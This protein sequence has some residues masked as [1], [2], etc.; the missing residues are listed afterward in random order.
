MCMKSGFKCVLFGPK[1]AHNLEV[2]WHCGTIASCWARNLSDELQERQGSSPHRGTEASRASS[3]TEWVLE[4]Q[5]EKCWVTVKVNK[6]KAGNLRASVLHKRCRQQRG[7]GG[8]VK[9]KGGWE[10]Y[11]VCAT[12]CAD[13]CVFVWIWWWDPRLLCKQH[14][15]TE[16]WGSFTVCVFTSHTV[17]PVVLCKPSK[18]S[19]TWDSECIISLQAPSSV[20]HFIFVFYSTPMRT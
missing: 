4:R 6:I 7:E 9:D 13:G 12:M 11:R 15:V 5:A 20:N 19:W 1:V 16:W 3:V 14:I 17:G 8:S 18:S 2:C 10:D